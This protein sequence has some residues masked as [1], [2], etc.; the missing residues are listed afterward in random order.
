MRSTITKNPVYLFRK[1][2][3]EEGEFETCS[4]SGLSVFEYRSQI[5]SGSLVIGRYS[6]L[7]YYK[8]LENEL[9]LNGSCLINSYRAHSYIAQM[10][11]TKEDLFDLTPKTWF[12]PWG[13][14][15][16]DNMSFVVK[17]L[18]NSRKTQWNTHMFAKDKHDVA[19]VARRLMDDTMIR[20]QGL[21]AREFVNL[22]KFGEQING[23]PVTNE[24]RFFCLD[25]QIIS[26]GFYWSNDIDDVPQ[27]KLQNTSKAFD[28]VNLA[29][30]RIPEYVRFVVIDVAEKENG[31]WIVVELNDG[32]MSGLSCNDAETLY[33][34]IE[35]ILIITEP[36]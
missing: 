17:G 16:P 7:P 6:V 8:E 28:L 15:L 23:L 5:P 26:H 36:A 9:A 21:V 22:V 12:S 25:G 11:W 30:K 24:W 27:E 35:Q 13:Y 10:E 33:G 34:N 29:L 31:D 32:Q 20:E 4:S 14:S 3:E 2:L 1:G 18:T 19:N